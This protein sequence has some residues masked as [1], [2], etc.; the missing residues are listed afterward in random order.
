MAKKIVS[1]TE[2]TGWTDPSKRKKVRKRRK[3]MTEDQKVAAAERLEKAR[4]V[5][6]AKNP[7]YGMSSIHESL[8]DMPDDYPVHPNKVKKW[9]KIQTE[10][11]NS[12]RKLNRQGVKG[13][14]ARQ[15]IH[16]GYIKNLKKF[17]RDGDYID[18]F[19]GEHQ[20]KKI[21]RKCVAQA[22]YW[23]GPKK[24]QPKFDVGVWYPL[25]GTVYTKEM[26]QSE[27]EE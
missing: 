20:D 9:I 3:P 22:Y 26:Q 15:L 2:N 10:L 27:E 17:L 13:A 4:A 1:K 23:E 5:R 12:E 16:E 11:A 25:L 6:A 18:N 8:R 24:D 7:D 19:Y 14:A 21:T